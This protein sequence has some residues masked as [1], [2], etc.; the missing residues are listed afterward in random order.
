[1]K[2]I[3]LKYRQLEDIMLIFMTLEILFGGK[4]VRRSLFSI[5]FFFEVDFS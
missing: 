3:V 5:F 2:E 1:M 4:S